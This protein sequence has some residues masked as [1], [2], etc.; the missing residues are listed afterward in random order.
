VTPYSLVKFIA[1]P[2]KRQYKSTSIHGVITHRTVFFL[3]AAVRTLT[4]YTE[5]SP[6]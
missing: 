6:S 2:L 4:K 3:A 5:E 1:V